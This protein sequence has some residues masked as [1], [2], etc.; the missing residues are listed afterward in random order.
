MAKRVDGLRD[1][2]E[3]VEKERD[4]AEAEAS[5]SKAQLQALQ[6]Q[7]PAPLFCARPAGSFPCLCF[8]VCSVS[9]VVIVRMCARL[10]LFAVP[11][12]ACA[13]FVCRSIASLLFC[14]VNA[15]R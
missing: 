13:S 4:A 12:V 1:A 5:S 10:D 7:V 11:C 2:I 8:V 6:A 14:S 15:L 3:K 9:K